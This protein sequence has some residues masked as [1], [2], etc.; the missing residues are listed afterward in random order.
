MLSV[1]QW[2]LITGRIKSKIFSMATKS[3]ITVSGYPFNFIFEAIPLIYSTM[4]TFVF[5]LIF[6]R[7]C[8]SQFHFRN[9]A[10]ILPSARN[11]LP[12][13]I[14]MTRSHILFGFLFKYSL[15]RKI[16]LDHPSNSL[17]HLFFFLSLFNFSDINIRIYNN[18][19]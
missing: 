11:I 7:M 2:L 19:T 18:I 12:P 6:S 3:F 14:H 8:C 15:L 10:L 13:D 1:L 4:S 17:D 9:F 16:F 5:S